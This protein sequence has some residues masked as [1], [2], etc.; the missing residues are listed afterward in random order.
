D[1]FV[2]CAQCGGKRFKEEV[3]DIKLRGISIGDMLEMSAREIL[4]RFP[5]NRQLAEALEPVIAMGLDYIRMGQPLSTLSGGEA[6]RLKLI[7][8]LSGGQSGDSKLFILDEPTTGL[9]PDDI[10]KLISVLHKLVE[11]RNTVLIVEHNLDIL[12]ACDWIVDLG[13][14]GGERGGKIICE[15]TP[16]TVSE[17]A[18]SIT[19]RYLG[20]LLAEAK[21]FGADQRE[22]LEAAEPLIGFS[23]FGAATPRNLHTSQS[24]EIEEVTS[25]A[26]LK[27]FAIPAQSHEIL[28]RGAREHNLALDEIRLP[29]GKM[30]VLTG[31][32]GSGKSTLA[33]DVLFAEGQRRYLECL[34]SYV[35]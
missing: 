10:S 25:I 5:E 23:A 18:Q 8:H 22:L 1:V 19:G 4:G 33:F 20:D 17:C 34:S 15:G 35:R 32:S 14:E 3:L 12:A 27:N 31:L 9:H 28:I 21:R 16:E 13:P 29:R 7:R 2:R 24:V 30:S 6:Q 11:K 26:D